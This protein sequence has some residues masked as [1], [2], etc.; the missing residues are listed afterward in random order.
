M[1][2]KYSGIEASIQYHS[3]Q[4]NFLESQSNTSSENYLYHQEKIA[5]LTQLLPAEKAREKVNPN[6]IIEV[7]GKVLISGVVLAIE[8]NGVL[9]TKLPITDFIRGR[10]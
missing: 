7:A 3:K 9:T 10:K 6:V 1:S 5:E 4:M 2:K 8:K